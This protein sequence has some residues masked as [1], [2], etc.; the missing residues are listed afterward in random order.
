MR[1]SGGSCRSGRELISTA[2]WFSTQAANTA[3]ASNSEGGRVPRDPCTRRPVQWPSTLVCGSRMPP[4]IRLVIVRLSDRSLEWT[5]PTTTSNR[6]S[7]SGVW[8]RSPL[9]EDV[10]LDAGEQREGAGVELAMTSSCSLQPLGA[11]AAR[12]GQVGEWS[13]IA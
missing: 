9:F 11:E 10:D 13:V 5:L 2:T 3:S 1:S 4:S 7:S 12:D 6:V 8:S